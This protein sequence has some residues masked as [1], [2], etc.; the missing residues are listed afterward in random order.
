M[1]ALPLSGYDCI[2]RARFHSADLV[3]YGMACTDAL[4]ELMSPPEVLLLPR[5]RRRTPHAARHKSTIRVA[6]TCG[7]RL[8]VNFGHMEHAASPDPV[9]MLVRMTG[10]ADVMRGMMLVGGGMSS[11]RRDELQNMRGRS[12]VPLA[13]LARR[14]V[15]D[16]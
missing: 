2:W 1:H 5:H 7:V 16:G 13:D 15:T 14:L 8:I 4:D 11:R 12:A 10:A 9:E 3:P 6:W